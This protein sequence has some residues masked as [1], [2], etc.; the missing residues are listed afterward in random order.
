MMS[1]LP[2]AGRPPRVNTADDGTKSVK[3]K[4]TVFS[5]KNGRAVG[6]NRAVRGPDYDYAKRL[7]QESAVD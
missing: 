7:V 2:R 5:F 3:V 1:K 6:S 4:G